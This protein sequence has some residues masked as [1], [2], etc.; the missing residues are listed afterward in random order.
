MKITKKTTNA[1]PV[2]KNSFYNHHLQSI[3]VY[4]KP[5]KDT[6]VKFVTKNLIPNITSKDTKICTQRNP[7]FNVARVKKFPCLQIHSN[8]ITEVVL[9]SKLIFVT[10]VGSHSQKNN[11]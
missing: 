8:D 10:F 7:N 5:Q 3:R 9:K 6:I 1:K 2:E 11:L 4:M